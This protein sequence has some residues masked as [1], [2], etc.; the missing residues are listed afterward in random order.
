MV[1]R[2]LLLYP[3]LFVDAGEALWHFL[4]KMHSEVLSHA[5]AVVVAVVVVVVGGAAV[6]AAGVVA[7]GVVAVVAA[8]ACCGIV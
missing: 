2:M 7:V 3:N 6:D 1:S 5:V 4:H 8:V